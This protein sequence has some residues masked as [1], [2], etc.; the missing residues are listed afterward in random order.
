MTV[1]QIKVKPRSRA[2]ELEE[3]GD[4]SFYAK[5]KAQP[6]DGKA[7]AELI[8]L[9]ASHFKVPKASVHIKFGATARIKLVTIAHS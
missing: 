3:L 5:L 2:S 6:V 7:N 4:G 8:A 9:V 1:I